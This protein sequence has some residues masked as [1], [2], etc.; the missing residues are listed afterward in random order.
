MQN[1]GE[2]IKDNWKHRHTLI[3]DEVKT[4]YIVADL[5]VW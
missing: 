2:Q 1:H 4:A 3:G 5:F